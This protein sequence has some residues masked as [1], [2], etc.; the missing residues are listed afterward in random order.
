MTGISVKRLKQEARQAA[1][2]RGHALGNFKQ[3]GSAYYAGCKNCNCGVW[4]TPKPAPN[5][6]D[7][8]GEAV[9]LDC[10]HKFA[11][12]ELSHGNLG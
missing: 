1:E 5:E 6:I 4:V 7:V 8:M 10:P 2:H 3:V 9:A 12:K 11:A